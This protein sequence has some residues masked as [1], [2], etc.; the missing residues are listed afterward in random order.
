MGDRDVSEERVVWRACAEIV[1]A[2]ASSRTAAEV[3]QAVLAA[4][5][6]IVPCEFA[7]IL[8][9]Q[10][11]ASWSLIGHKEDQE[12]LRQRQWHYAQ[13]M[14]EAELAQIGTRFSV[15][16]EI[17]GAE[18]RERM[19][20]YSD[21]MRPNRQSGFVTRYWLTD[22]RLWGMGLS[23][24]GSSF[25]SSEC[26]RL[27][28]LFPHLRAAM[29]AGRWFASAAGD[30]PIDGAARWSLTA[31]EERITSLIVRG[32]T[33]GEAASVLGVSQNTVRNALAKIFKKVGV[34]S[35]SELVFV[36]QGQAQDAE[37]HET[38]GDAYRRQVSAARAVDAGSA[39]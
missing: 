16:S 5:A 2:L 10:P 12:I 1:E 18:R 7:A 37:V 14:T 24:G 6:R 21:F 11:G 39:T 15:D 26:A 8:A 38:H 19:S 27:D 20:V 23:R 30:A 3:G 25:S 34:A 31:A 35:R 4:V 17:F 22:G 13:E 32:L 29:R 36:V 9:A 33:N 28:A